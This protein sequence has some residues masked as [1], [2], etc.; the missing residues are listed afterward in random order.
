MANFTNTATLSYSGGT[1][2][3]NT[4]TGTVQ[5]ELTAVKTAVNDTYRFGDNV[6]YVISLVNS[7]GCAFNGLAL[8]DDMG[9]FF[10]GTQRVVPLEYNTGTARYY[11]NGTLQEP[12]VVTQG[13]NLMFTGISV[14]AEGNAL[15]IYEAT[16]TRFAPPDNEGV[17]TNTVTIT[18]DSLCERI[19]AS[20]AVKADASPAL[21]VSKAVCPS[22]V[23][24]GG[25]VTYTFTVQNSGNTEALAEDEI[26]LT[27]IFEPR[28]N[29]NSVSFNGTL[30]TSNV[31]YTYSMTTGQFATERGQITVPAAV[32]TKDSDCGWVVT[33]GVSTLVITGT[34]I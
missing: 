21:T 29:I 11:V 32:Y 6:T 15:V 28:L 20:T 7:G 18:G 17:I 30:W 31:N 10:S 5:D 1:V 3:S 33:P 12:P 26:V 13:Q 8:T 19:T 14:P 23:T 2:N 34:I 16:V 4:V 27:D 22:V 24:A 9:A 25:T